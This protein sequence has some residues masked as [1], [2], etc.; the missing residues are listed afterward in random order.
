MKWNKLH[1]VYSTSNCDIRH[2][3][4][5]FRFGPSLTGYGIGDRIT[6]KPLKIIYIQWSFKKIKDA[7]S[8]WQ[9]S[10]KF[11]K[12]ILPNNTHLQ[13]VNQGNDTD[14]DGCT[15][16]WELKWVYDPNKWEDHANLDPD[17]DGLNNIEEC[18]TDQWGS[19]P[20]YKDIFLEID[21]F[22]TNSTDGP[23]KPMDD[24]IE[25]IVKVFKRHKINIHVDNGNLGGGEEIDFTQDY[26]W[27]NK[28]DFYWDYFLHN[29]LN[30]PRKGVFHYGLICNTGPG[31]YALFGW[32]H[33]DSFQCV[34]KFM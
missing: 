17:N 8:D 7:G 13:I 19:N 22:K 3:W 9:T 15:N 25:K 6:F 21:W 34:P 10:D 11:E 5:G 27:L 2:N 23:N 20:K 29:D 30:N 28:L 26:T 18:F 24:Q 33:M 32:D 31:G 16:E 1:G 4:W 14:N 12:I